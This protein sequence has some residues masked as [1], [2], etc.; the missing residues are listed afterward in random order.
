MVCCKIVRRLVLTS[1]VKGTGIGLMHSLL[2]SLPLPPVPTSR[3]FI[4]MAL[5][6]EQPKCLFHIDDTFSLHTAF[7]TKTGASSDSGIVVSG[8]LRFGRLKIGDKIVIGPFPSEE[9]DPRGAMPQDRPSPGSYGLSLSHPSSA[10][11]AR[12][13]MRNAVIKA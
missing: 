10:E 12:I 7:N 5:N 9:D 2:Q 8:H 11:L 3:N 6:P 13:A 4:G 1:A